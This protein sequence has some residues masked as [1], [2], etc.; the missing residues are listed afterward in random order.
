MADIKS[1]EVIGDIFTE[2]NKTKKIFKIYQIIKRFIKCNTCDE[3]YRLIHK[4]DNQLKL[5][6]QILNI[7]NYDTLLVDE[8]TGKIPQI[9]M[10][11]G[12]IYEIKEIWTQKFLL[13]MFGFA[14]DYTTKSHIADDNVKEYNPKQLNLYFNY[15]LGFRYF[16]V[17]DICL[18]EGSWDKTYIDDFCKCGNSFKFQKFI[19]NSL[20]LNNTFEEFYKKI[21]KYRR[22]REYPENFKDVDSDRFENL[23][24]NIEKFFIDKLN[25]NI[26]ISLGEIDSTTNKYKHE[27][28]K[29]TSCQIITYNELLEEINKVITTQ[30][31]NYGFIK[32]NKYEKN[33]YLEKINEEIE[34]FNKDLLIIFNK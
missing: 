1:F 14:P 23:A 25:L 31:A 7:F 5:L 9:Y 19:I 17:N 33:G 34:S 32:L 12:S 18:A 4:I 30:N 22:F 11:S 13:T 20:I 27:N 16:F 10:H 21:Q 28:V 3:Q 29:I 6:N 26:T 24:R 2:V 8:E 15:N